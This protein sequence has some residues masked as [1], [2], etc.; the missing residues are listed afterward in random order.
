MRAH[1][2]GKGRGCQEEQG[3]V[4][5]QVVARNRVPMPTTGAWSVLVN[6]LVVGA[7][8][9]ANTAALLK[10]RGEFGARVHP[11]FERDARH[12]ARAIAQQRCHVARARA[13]ACHV[14]LLLCD[15]SNSR[16]GVRRHSLHGKSPAC[17][18]CGCVEWV[19]GG[20]TANGDGGWRCGCVVMGGPRAAGR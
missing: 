13:R 12:A 7:V 2:S 15:G 19:A 1:R 10:R 17:V 16:P 11:H 14:P 18:L 3:S 9:A 4:A 8:A 20:W 5:R 6:T